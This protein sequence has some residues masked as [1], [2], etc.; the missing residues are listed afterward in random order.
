MGKFALLIGVSEYSEGEDPLSDL[1]A[2]LNDVRQLAEVLEDQNIGGFQVKSLE[3][4]SGG[5]MRSEIE[6][7]FADR[8]ADDLVL[9]YFSGHGITDQKGQF[10]FSTP[11]TRK[12]QRGFLVKSSAIP[13][14]EV[15]GYMDDCASDRM[16]VILDC[17]HSGAF[18][19]LI[20]RDAGEIK[21]E[22]QLGGRGR[23][24][25]TASAAIDYSYERSG[26]E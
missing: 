1:P 14:Q 26:E 23:V 6:A 15:H 24:V 18:G 3:N 9:L 16:V 11:K 2:A 22:P 13:A 5:Q 12:D 4:P 17:C 8:N 19:D 10:F 20:S 25:L 7:L 21:F